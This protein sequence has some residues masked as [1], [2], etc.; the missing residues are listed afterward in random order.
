MES[1]AQVVRGTGATPRLVALVLVVGCLSLAL[2]SCDR[3]TAVEVGTRPASGYQ[4]EGRILDRLGVPMEGIE[5]YPY[6]DLVYASSDT[7]PAREYEVKDSVTM[8]TVRVLSSEDSVVRE[9]AS[10]F[11][12][13]GFLLV[14]WDRKD[15]AGSDVPS[16][17]YR[18]CYIVGGQIVASYGVLVEGTLTAR[19][20]ATG[21]FT[22]SNRH[23]PL[24]FAPVPLY[25]RDSSVF[26]GTYS[27]GSAVFLELTTPTTIHTVGVRPSKDRVTAVSLVLE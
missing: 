18:V 19:T 9:L 11:Y 6:Y 27:V 3:P 26:Y 13:P 24:G 21:T 5:V 20:D 10:G 22:L 4:I 2:A 23:L 8:V 7:A 1:Q 17:A 12:Q 15:S 14:V 25:S 16:G